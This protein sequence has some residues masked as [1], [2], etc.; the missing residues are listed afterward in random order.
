MGIYLYNNLALIHFCMHIVNHS[1]LINC[2]GSKYIVTRS[3]NTQFK[4]K[5]EKKKHISKFCNVSDKEEKIRRIAVFYPNIDL[6][7]LWL[8]KLRRFSCVSICRKSSAPV[9]RVQIHWGNI[10][11]LLRYGP[12]DQN[13]GQPGPRWNEFQALI[14][15]PKQ[16]WRSRYN[17]KSSVTSGDWFPSFTSY[18]QNRIAD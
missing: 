6:L 14:F 12:S 9:H 16:I 13:L 11:F 4:F 18:K 17:L 7:S 8:L 10:I 3:T 5:K 15:V 1:V 2:S